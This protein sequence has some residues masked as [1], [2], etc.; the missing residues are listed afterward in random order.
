MILDKGVAALAHALPSSSLEQ[1]RLEFALYIGKERA[2]AL[3]ARLGATDLRINSTV[4]ELDLDGNR[5]GDEGA[6][7]F[8]DCL[9]SG[10]ALTKLRFSCQGEPLGGGRLGI[11]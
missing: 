11:Q 9:K 7:D 3:G 8:S 1:L 10:T 6:I 4:E 2:A 5:V